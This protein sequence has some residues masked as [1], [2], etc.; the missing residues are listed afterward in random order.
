MTRCRAALVAGVL[1]VVALAG[2]TAASPGPFDTPQADEDV[3]PAALTDYHHLDPASTRFVDTVSDAVV[4]V[5]RS[6]ER[7]DACL[8][9]APESSDPADPQDDWVSACSG[10]GGEI[11]LNGRGIPSLRFDPQGLP[12]DDGWTNLD[13][14]VQVND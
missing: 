9:A 10:G 1:G 6:D 12:E 7:G 11:G 4:Y 14:W 3:L 8:L 13:A 5:A 2:C